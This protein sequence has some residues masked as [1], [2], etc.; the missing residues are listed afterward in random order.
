MIP[1]NDDKK[2]DRK[3]NKYWER[4]A[5]LRDHPFPT[6]LEPI[7]K[8]NRLEYKWSRHQDIVES[9]SL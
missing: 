7:H 9:D 4:K 8:L 1:I 2:K 5:N 6:K 3:D